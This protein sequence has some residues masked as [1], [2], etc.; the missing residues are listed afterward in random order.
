[1]YDYTS[2]TRNLDQARHQRSSLVVVEALRLGEVLPG[3][4]GEGVADRGAG[5]FGGVAA[6]AAAA[7]EDFAGDLEEL[8][9]GGELLGDYRH[10]LL[11]AEEL[12]DHPPR[13]AVVG[14][15]LPERHG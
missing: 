15:H 6:E 12:V 13:P 3:A 7:D 5:S 14:V 4:E 9:V 1:M 10:R 11:V 2:L 8:V